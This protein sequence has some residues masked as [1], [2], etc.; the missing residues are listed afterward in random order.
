MGGVMIGL[1]L[2]EYECGC[3]GLAPD[4]QG[5]ILLVQNSGAPYDNDMALYEADHHEGK[6]YVPLAE[7]RAI[8]LT[9][10]LNKLVQQGYRFRDIKYALLE[11]GDV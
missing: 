6:R 7:D 10:E 9:Q 1:P 11:P 8:R 2:V 3:I 4:A 5:R